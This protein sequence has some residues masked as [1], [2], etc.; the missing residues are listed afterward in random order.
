MLWHIVIFFFPSKAPLS[1]NKIL[2]SLPY[3]RS[4]NV[5][6]AYVIIDMGSFLTL[7][8]LHTY[9]EVLTKQFPVI[10]CLELN[11]FRIAHAPQTTKNV[12]RL[13]AVF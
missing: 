3:H 10:F 13:N 8:S 6:Y 4:Y 9:M 7:I 1:T 11:V 12:D 5:S 2:F